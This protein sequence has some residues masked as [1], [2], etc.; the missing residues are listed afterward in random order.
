MLNFTHYTPTKIFFGKDTHKE[1][2][3]IIKD[4][5]FKKILFHYGK[6]SIKKTGLYDEI[7]SSLKENNIEF[8]E[9]GGVKP[10]PEL[11][12]VKKGIEIAKENKVELVLAVGGGSVIDSSKAISAGALVDFDPFLFNL[13][14][15]TPE[16]TIP[17][18]TV[19]TISAAGSEMS[20]SCVITNEE[21]QLKR[22]FNSDLIRPLFSVMNPELTCT[23]PPFQTACGIVDIMMHTLE[24]YFSKTTDADLTDRISEGILKSVI[25][26]GRVAMADPYNYEAR[27]TLMWGSSLSH[28]GLTGCMKDVFMTCH[29][30]AHEINGIFDDMAHGETLAIVFPAWAKYMVKHAREKFCQFAVRV[31]DCEY[32]FENPEKTALEG[33][34]KIE[35]FFKEIGMPTSFKETPQVDLERLPEMAVKCTNFG[36]RKLDCY[37]PLGKDEI[38]AIYNLM[39]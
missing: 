3:K 5:G 7:V 10:N 24:R 4:Y 11:S 30:I 37:I 17:V 12:L 9:L 35:S 23:L 32:D 34:A 36:K 1:V 31:M 20:N 18:A 21:T 2:G 28:N 6:E 27:A 16:K 26:A 15:K 33:I 39:K 22:G 38:E 8:I 13:K 29:Q 25:S 14:E 19:L